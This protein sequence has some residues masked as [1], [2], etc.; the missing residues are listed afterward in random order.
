MTTARTQLLDWL[1]NA[2]A[3]DVRSEEML[4]TH[5]RAWRPGEASAWDAVSGAP[6]LPAARFAVIRR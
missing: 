2:H 3:M 4:T 5:I 1:R 6:M